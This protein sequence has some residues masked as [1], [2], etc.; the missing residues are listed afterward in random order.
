[1]GV[2]RLEDVRSILLGMRGSLLAAELYIRNDCIRYEGRRYDDDER[3]DIE[4]LLLSL[5]A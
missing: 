1:M 4:E 2:M 3:L 5:Q